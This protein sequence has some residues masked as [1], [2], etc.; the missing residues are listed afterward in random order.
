MRRVTDIKC[1]KCGNV[2]SASEHTQC[3]KCAKVAEKD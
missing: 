3:P 2:F 1:E